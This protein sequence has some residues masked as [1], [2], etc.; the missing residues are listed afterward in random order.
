MLTYYTNQSI[1]P[2][3]WYFFARENTCGLFESRQFKVTNLEQ[4]A[5]HYMESGNT[6]KRG[7]NNSNFQP[8]SSD[9][10]CKIFPFGLM[11]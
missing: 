3:H 8:S 6:G 10:R 5:K 9:N 4:L 7:A 11:R 1:E 2:I